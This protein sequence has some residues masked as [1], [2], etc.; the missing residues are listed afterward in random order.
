M[1][2]VFKHHSNITLF[3]TTFYSITVGLHYALD[4]ITDSKYTLLCFLTT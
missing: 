2:I 1:F 3:Q 4:G